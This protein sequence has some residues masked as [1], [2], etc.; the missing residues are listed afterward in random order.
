M[1]LITDVLLLTMGTLFGAGLTAAYAG[2]YPVDFMESTPWRETAMMAVGAVTAGVLWT[3]LFHPALLVVAGGFA[4]VSSMTTI[5][6]IDP[7][8]F[9]DDPHPSRMAVYA[10][11]AGGVT[12]LSW[13]DV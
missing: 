10:L 3:M 11:T 1:L 4:G 2:E 8:G 7:Q 5:A 9:M 13:L 12:L 6:G